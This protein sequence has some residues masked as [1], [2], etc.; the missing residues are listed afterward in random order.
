MERGDR[1]GE[2][3]QQYEQGFPEEPKKTVLLLA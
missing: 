2:Q 3:K 1:D